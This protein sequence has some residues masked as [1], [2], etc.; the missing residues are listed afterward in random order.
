MK[1]IFL[2]VNVVLDYLEHRDSGFEID[3]L[4]ENESGFELYMSALSIHIIVYVLKIKSGSAYNKLLRLILDKVNL[5]PLTDSIVRT[6]LAKKYFD[7]EDLLQFQSA[8]DFCDTILTRDLKDFL[9]IKKA[10]NSTI[11]IINKV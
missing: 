3:K 7:F 11:N 10:L 9:K 1:K 2:D 6:S 5:I 8:I 4:F